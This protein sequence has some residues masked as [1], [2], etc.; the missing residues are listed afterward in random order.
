MYFVK[1][2]NKENRKDSDMDYVAELEKDVRF[3]EAM[4]SCLNCGICSAICPAAEFYNYDPRMIVT[5][6]QRRNNDEIEALLKSNTIWYC[7]QCMSC[8]TRCP[9]GNAAGMVIQALRALSQKCGFFTESEKGRQQYGLKKTIGE[10]ILKYGYCVH[11]ALVKPELHPEQG[12]VWDWIYQNKEAIY[13]RVGANLYK[14]G[15][16]AMRKIHQ[17]NLDELAEIFKVTGGQELYDV[18]ESESK[19]KAAEMHMSTDD[20]NNEYLMH[21]ITYNSNEHQD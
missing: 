1:L 2:Q 8:K 18:I 21:V 3:Q 9:R 17:K 19:K 20:D 5:T 13:D 10:S 14:D 6:V 7:G 4:H 11:P 15:A 12:V 16:G